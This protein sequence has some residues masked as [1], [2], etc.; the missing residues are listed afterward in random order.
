MCHFNQN[1]LQLAEGHTSG[2][3]LPSFFNALYD[4]S[5]DISSSA[6][7]FGD[8]TSFYI[9][10]DVDSVFWDFGDTAAGAENT[11]NLTSPLHQFSAPGDYLVTAT[12]VRGNF[13]YPS[14]LSVTITAP[15]SLALNIGN[16]TILCN[17][18]SLVLNASNRNA[19][20]LWQDMST[21]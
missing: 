18:D 14:D 1:S 19:T 9:S 13:S 4:F 10:G 6:F 5:F 12:A 15:D 16:D 20:Y 8:S 7:C 17:G 21:S 3:G 2:I 11:S